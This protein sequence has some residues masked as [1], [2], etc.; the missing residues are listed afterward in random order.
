MILRSVALS[1]C[2]AVLCLS[3]LGGCAQPVNTA[4]TIPSSGPAPANPATT[5]PPAAGVASPGTTAA[6]ADAPLLDEQA[7]PSTTAPSA[8]TLGQ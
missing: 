1:L 5:T 2:V 4:S 3:L 7:P 6:P 8:M